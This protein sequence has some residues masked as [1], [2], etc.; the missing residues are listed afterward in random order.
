MALLIL[1]HYVFKKDKRDVVYEIRVRKTAVD[2]LR[3]ERYSDALCSV[4]DLNLSSALSLRE[5]CKSC[6]NFQRAWPFR[7]QNIYCRCIL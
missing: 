5:N 1:Y 3:N 2:D 7:N 6:R 4:V